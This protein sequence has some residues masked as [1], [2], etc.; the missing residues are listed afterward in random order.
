ME[1]PRP[2]EVNYRASQVDGTWLIW[3]VLQCDRPSPQGWPGPGL[4]RHPEGMRRLVVFLFC[5]EGQIT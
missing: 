2:G 3:A 5:F 1:K 4:G